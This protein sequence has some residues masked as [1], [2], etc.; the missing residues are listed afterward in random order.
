MKLPRW[1]CRNNALLERQLE[2]W[3][4]AQLDKLDNDL[5]TERDIEIMHEWTDQEFWSEE[6]FWRQQ[7]RAR[8]VKAAKAKNKKLLWRLAANDYE[9]QQLALWLLTRG[10]GRPKGSWPTDIVGEK[11]ALL[12]RAAIDVVRICDIWQDKLGHR[13]RK[14][15]P[16]AVEIAARR[17]GVDEDELGRFRKN[18]ARPNYR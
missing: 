11:R 5:V 3:T 8:I 7:Q 10:R 12:E 1:D 18:F 9:F 13:N 2:E 17:W 6:Y 4:L 16:T 14:E 15:R